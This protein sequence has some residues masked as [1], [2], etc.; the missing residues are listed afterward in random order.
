MATLF[1]DQN[2]NIVWVGSSCHSSTADGDYCMVAWTGTD[3]T[4]YGARR[5]KCVSQSL[6]EEI[7]HSFESSHGTYG[8][9]LD[10]EPIQYFSGYSLDGEFQVA[11]F[12]TSGLAQGPH[13]LKISNEYARKTGQPSDY[14]WLDI[15][16]VAVMGNL[17]AASSTV[18]STPTSTTTLPTSSYT[19]NLSY[20]LA[21]GQYSVSSMMPILTTATIPMISGDPFVSSPASQSSTDPTTTDPSSTST[22]VSDVQQTKA[23]DATNR[24]SAFAVS[25]AVIV[26]SILFI[27][28]VAIWWLWRRRKRLQAERFEED[29]QDS[30]AR[31]P[32]A[33]R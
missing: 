1:D 15:D 4:V 25:A 3:I 16:S 30:L 32:P 20:S 2:Q 14:V 27:G 8:A 7:A 18:T 29:V 24:T 10:D 26:I 12:G 33:W 11:L 19:A 17:I 23:S 31:P 5:K 28:I 9:Q 13:E 6:G 22:D 21:T